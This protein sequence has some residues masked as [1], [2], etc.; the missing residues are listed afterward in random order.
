LDKA[1]LKEDDDTLQSTFNTTS[2]PV[3]KMTEMVIEKSP[4]IFEAHYHTTVEILK[5]IPL[6]AETGKVQTTVEEQERHYGQKS[7]HLANIQQVQELQEHAHSQLLKQ[8]AFEQA[9]FERQLEEQIKNKKA[10]IDQLYKE[11]S[12]DRESGNSTETQ[13][14]S[15][16]SE[17]KQLDPQNLAESQQDQ[18]SEQHLSPEPPGERTFGERIKPPHVYMDPPPLPVKLRPVNDLRGPPE[19]SVYRLV[20]V[21]Q[22]QNPSGAVPHQ[23]SGVRLAPP[24]E[25]LPEY[26]F[27]PQFQDP[28]LRKHLGRPILSQ[29]QLENEQRKRNHFER[30]HQQLRLEADIGRLQAEE[31]R[32]D[33]LKQSIRA[34]REHP[35]RNDYHLD[36]QPPPQDLSSPPV[37]QSSQAEQILQDLQAGRIQPVLIPAGQI[38]GLFLPP[39]QHAPLVLSHA[40]LNQQLL[41]DEH[42]KQQQIR[43]EQLQQQIEA[44]NLQQQQIQAGQLQ[45]QQ[46]QAGQLQQ[47]QIQPEQLQE[48]QIQSEQLQQQRIQAEHLRQQQIQAEQLEHQQIQSEQLQQQ[49]IQAEHLQ[50][51]Q[52]QAEQFQQQQI[53]AGQIQQ[54]QIKAGQI[55]L[56]EEEKQRQ[57]IQEE[58]DQQLQLQAE[59]AQQQQVQ[60]EQ[61]RQAGRLK[62]QDL[63][64]QLHQIQEAQH[65]GIE[66]QGETYIGTSQKPE[67]L[68]E[69]QHEKI[70][71]PERLQQSLGTGE[72]VTQEP[73]SAL[74]LI[75]QIEAALQQHELELREQQIQAELL[76]G[77]Q[78]NLEDLQ[79]QSLETEENKQSQEQGASSE[80]R[81]QASAETPDDSRKSIDS[82][83]AQRIE[84]S[85]EQIAEETDNHQQAPLNHA[86]GSEQV[87]QVLQL[88]S[89]PQ[90][91]LPQVTIVQLQQAPAG[92]EQLQVLSNDHPHA[93]QPVLLEDHPVP[94]PPSDTNL[95]Q[96]QAPPAHVNVE[97]DK[98]LSPPPPPSVPLSLP[99]SHNIE[100]SRVIQRHPAPRPTTASYAAQVQKHRETD[101]SHKAVPGIDFDK[102]VHCAERVFSYT[103]GNGGGHPWNRNTRRANLRKLCIE[104][105]GFKPPLVPSTPIEEDG[106]PI[107]PPPPPVLS[108]HNID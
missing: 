102:Q 100:P 54:Q 80:D 19:G 59:Q 57:Q 85:A 87:V 97:A 6:D 58:N 35:L 60:I 92:T 104:Y 4:A 22:L 50:Q 71:Q 7:E 96:P 3:E 95:L 76:P 40:Q 98:H 18:S 14:H 45:Q 79:Q 8:R 37:R 2:K 77:N 75:Q 16:S 106:Q 32:A 70:P 39:P 83:P 73:I 47:Q 20:P 108:H 15:V 12:S 107:G 36:L 46:I 56:Q 64:Q 101:L 74:P 69:Q 86:A 27:R 41:E 81:T 49:Q 21:L 10:E 91:Q 93:P 9:M 99:P 72:L 94:P 52:I 67:I 68:E 63:P 89:D 105:G 44:E 62:E 66:I 55:Q 30:L 61:E 51:Q 5:S 24:S 13:T 53:Q 103:N 26:A 33:A 43:I 31:L 23:E 11:M 38:R 1:H 65:P 34:E 25:V 78:I 29:K 84:S 48:Q 82:E 28:V 42:I 90:I 17:N 88:N